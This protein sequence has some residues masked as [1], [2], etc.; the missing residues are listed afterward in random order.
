MDQIDKKY[1]KK[2]HR[3]YYQIYYILGEITLLYSYKFNNVVLISTRYNTCFLFTLVAA[4][5]F[6]FS[7]NISK[8]IYAQS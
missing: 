6:R 2:K 7:K 3:F 5:S 4:F 8:L 1:K